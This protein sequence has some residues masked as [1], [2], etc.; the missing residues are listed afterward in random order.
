MDGDAL[1]DANG[2]LVIRAT[3]FARD[4]TTVVLEAVVAPIPLPAIVTNG[5]L[6]IS[7]NPT[8]S[9]SDGDVHSNGDLTISGSADIT[10]D[11]TT[12]GTLTC[13]AP[14]SQ[15]S[16]T[17][18]EGATPLPVPT[19]RTIDYKFWANFILTDDGFVTQ[20]DGTP[21][22]E[23]TSQHACRSAYGWS[24]DG[25]GVGW[26]VGSSG[27]P[28][29]GTYYVEGIATVSGSPG[30][31]SDPIQ[32]SIIAEG[33][34]DISGNPD[35]TPDTPDLLFV[36]DGDLQISGGIDTPL[37]IQE[38]MLVHEQIQIS[39][40]PTLAWQIIVEDAASVSTL[41][42]SS[43]ISGNPTIVYDGNL[44]TGLYRVV[45]WRD[46]R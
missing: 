38:Q 21:L 11:G 28:L 14:C 20:Q 46:V 27:T 29:D 43:Q 39:G 12:S 18:A 13:T 15:I 25:A 10:G 7:G 36:T 26:S 44:G 33:S 5:D 19:V 40:N 41:V 6:V 3:G 2:K 35:L 16:G 22:C 32:V 37:H 34:I 42:T 4:D 24:Y 45:S 31:T 17:Q 23:A 1:N 30:T 9:G 8:I